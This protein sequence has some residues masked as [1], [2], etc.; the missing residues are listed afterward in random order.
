MSPK[1]VLVS[2]EVRKSQFLHA[3]TQAFAYLLSYFAKTGPTKAKLRQ[4]PLQEFYTLQVLHLF[5]S[6]S[7]FGR[8]RLKTF[9]RI[10]P[11]SPALVSCHA[12]IVVLIILNPP[13][14][15]K[16]RH[17]VAMRFTVDAT[18]GKRWTLRWAQEQPVFNI[19]YLNELIL[20]LYYSS[21]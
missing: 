21:S 16:T 7:F 12:Q 2:V 18:L 17:M 10:N 4:A 19:L 20:Q 5:L 9:M 15:C 8:T 6:K 13:S 11:P 3:A 14:P 1:I